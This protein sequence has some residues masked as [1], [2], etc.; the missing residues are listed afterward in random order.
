MSYTG[1]RP[2]EQVEQRFNV[3]LFSVQW[4]PNRGSIPAGYGAADGQL[5]SRNSFPDAAIGVLAG[6][7]PTVAEATWLSTPLERG[8]Y[9]VGDGSTTIRLP[10]YNGKYAGSLGALFLRGDGT[11]SAAV[12]GA[13]QLDEFKSHTH[14][15]NSAPAS[16]SGAT[17]ASSGILSSSQTGATGGAETRPLNVTG[18]W[19][20][21]LFGAVTNVGSADA[22]QLASDYANIIGR[23]AAL[24]L[25]QFG[26]GQTD[27]DVTGSRSKATLYTNSTGRPILVSINP[28]ATSSATSS[29]TVNGVVV[30]SLA[31]GSAT[32][33]A[34][35]DWVVDPG[36]TYQFDS[37]TTILR[38]VEKR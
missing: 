17:G 33:T 29:L 4:W 27:Q 32:V 1:N 22:A 7:V 24:E 31:F 15:Q 30:K 2:A 18:C 26:A 21:K 34:P 38:W 14:T 11:L 3:P 20:I 19:I 5:I 28:T 12:A 35:L 8:K 25:S 6:N 16:Y 37:T 10:D 36:D 9:T 13:I 23:V